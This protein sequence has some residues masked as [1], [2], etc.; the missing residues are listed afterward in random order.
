MSSLLL[1]I[2]L[3]VLAIVCP[4]GLMVYGLSRDVSSDSH[5]RLLGFML[6]YGGV[7]LTATLLAW[8]RI[9]YPS[10]WAESEPTVYWVL[11]ALCLYGIA[12]AALMSS[13]PSRG[14]AAHLRRK[15]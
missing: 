11:A 5:S 3:L 6:W 9:N 8:Y 15:A 4:L 10:A 1:N 14:A 7:G 2:L 13:S 12:A